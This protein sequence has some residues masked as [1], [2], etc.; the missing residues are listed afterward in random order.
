MICNI[1]Q[2]DKLVFPATVDNVTSL[3]VNNMETPRL[4]I[5]NEVEKIVE[6]LCDNNIIRR[7]Q[8]KQGAADTYTFYSEEEMKVA[9]LIQSQVA[10]NNTQ[11][12][13]LKEIFGKYIAALKNKE[14]YMTRSFS[15]GLDIKQRHFLHTNN[16]DVVVEFA[17]DPDYD[18]ADALALQNQPNRMVYYLGPQFRSNKRLYSACDWY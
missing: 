16:P 12:E 1:S 17:M 2:T 15:V 7:E 4:T 8:G 9:Q 13:Q 5:K 3:L 11:A 6:F 18:S 10:D 14:Q